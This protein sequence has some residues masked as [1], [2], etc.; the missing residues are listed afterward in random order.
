MSAMTAVLRQA[1]RRARAWARG[2]GRQF[3]GTL[4]RCL[5]AMAA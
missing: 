5:G 1:T 2:R 4:L 3:L